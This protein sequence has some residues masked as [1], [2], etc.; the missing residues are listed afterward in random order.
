MLFGGFLFFL[1]NPWTVLR[2]KPRP[3]LYKVSII[4]EWS[5]FL[6]SRHKL[7]AEDS[8]NV[9]SVCARKS[10]G[11]VS[12][13]SR[14]SCF[15]HMIAGDRSAEG[16]WLYHRSYCRNTLIYAHTTLRTPDL[17][18]QPRFANV[19]CAWSWRLCGISPCYSSR[20]LEGLHYLLLIQRRNIASQQAWI[21]IISR[22]WNVACTL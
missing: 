5:F 10:S 9:M 1:P 8:R 2:N 22:H 18:R 15:S 19:T 7:Y 13:T 4:F 11:P 21:W 20:L 17:W 16:Y 12:Q 6:V 14:P 3:P